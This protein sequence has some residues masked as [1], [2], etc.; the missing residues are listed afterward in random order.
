[1]QPASDTNDLANQLSRLKANH[2]QQHT[3]LQ[4]H[5]QLLTDLLIDCDLTYPSAK[6]LYKRLENPS[7]EP[8]ALGQMLAGLAKLKVINIYA[9]RHNRNLYDLTGDAPARMHHLSKQLM[10]SS[11]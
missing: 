8:Q 3:L 11:D 6:Q 9:D 4:R 2:P 1:M 10:D 7:F 5:H